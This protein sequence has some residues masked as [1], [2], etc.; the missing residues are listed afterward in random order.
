[1]KRL[2]LAAMAAA[3]L[4]ALALSLADARA[5][6]GDAISDPAAMTEI[7]SQLDAADQVSFLADVN[8]AISNMPG[9][10]TEKISKFL[11]ANT[12]AMKGAAPGNLPSMLAETFATVPPEALTVINEQFAANVFNRASDP[13]VNYTDEQFAD[14]AKQTMAKVQERNAS[15]DNAGVRDAFA[16]LMLV[17]ASNGSPADL[18]DTLIAG[19][20]DEKTR[21]LAASEW[22]PAALGQG[23]EKSYDPMLAASD[24][25]EEPDYNLVLQLSAIQAA[26]SMMLR[27]GSDVG[28][29]PGDQDGG[30]DEGLNKLPFFYNTAVLYSGLGTKGSGRK[31]GSGVVYDENGNAIG[32]GGTPV[33]RGDNPRPVGPGGRPVGP[34]SPVEP[35]GYQGQTIY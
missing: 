19:L 23:Q 34:D 6:I 27:L 3:A 21:E 12:A 29:I 17:R 10:E 4:P 26:D 28:A 30:L 35:G 24:A 14:I 22:F 16:A 5:K 7:V 31:I 1:M 25:G 15:A 13:A 20:P 9:S 32:P 11:D 18:A 33:S 8:D 2:I